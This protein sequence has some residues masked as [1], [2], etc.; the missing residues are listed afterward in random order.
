MLRLIIALVIVITLIVIGVYFYK[1]NSTK[2]PPAADIPVVQTPAVQYI[3]CYA[4]GP[5]GDRDFSGKY[6]NEI[7]FNSCVSVGRNMGT[8]YIGFQGNPTTGTGTCWFGDSYGKHGR[9]DDCIVKDPA[10]NVMGQWA[11][12][13]YQLN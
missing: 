4:D 7:D 6:R 3:G 12:A 9:G 5:D 10:G 13:V 8:K 2:Q 1:K 11:N